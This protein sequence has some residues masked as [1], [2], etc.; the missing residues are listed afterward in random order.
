MCLIFIVKFFFSFFFL[1]NQTVENWE[2]KIEF[3]IQAKGSDYDPFFLYCKSEQGFLTKIFYHVY[4]NRQIWKVKYSQSTKTKI[5][6][7]KL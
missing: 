5:L 1:A 3:S 4:S 2:L 6:L 7:L